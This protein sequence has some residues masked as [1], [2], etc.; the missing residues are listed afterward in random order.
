MDHYAP[1]PRTAGALGYAL[2]HLTP[3]YYR[4]VFHGGESPAFD[5]VRVGIGLGLSHGLI[6]GLMV[7]SIIVLAVGFFRVPVAQKGSE[8]GNGVFRRL[9][10]R[11][12][13]CPKRC[14][15]WIISET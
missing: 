14:K 2:A 8:R 13:T 6:A 1:R 7:G 5:P 4:S 3:F 12:R 15:P 9:M 11:L 10:R